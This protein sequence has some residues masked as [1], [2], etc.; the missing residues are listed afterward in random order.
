VQG[1]RKVWP[2]GFKIRMHTTGPGTGSSLFVRLKQQNNTATVRPL[3]QR[4]GNTGHDRHMSIMSTLMPHTV[5]NR[6]V[7]QI[8]IHLMNWQSIQLGPEHHRFAGFCAIIDR[9]KSGP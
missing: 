9:C 4:L 5:V 6:S 2:D 3:L 8:L 7:G 1:K